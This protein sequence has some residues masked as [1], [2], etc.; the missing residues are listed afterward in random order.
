MQWPLA[1][2]KP[3]VQLVPS[4]AV[5][6]AGHVAEEPVHISAGSHSPV[7]GRQVCVDGANWQLLQ[8]SSLESSQTAL[9]LNLQVAA[10]QHWFPAQLAVPPQSQSSPA[11]T[12]PLPHCCPVIVVTPLLLL[13]QKVLTLFRWKAEQILP[14]EQGLNA[15]MPWPVEGFMRYFSPA[16]QVP[17]LRGQHC[18][19]LDV[20]SAQVELVQS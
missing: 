6:S 20:P 16:S 7:L 14:M 3:P 11:S 4:V 19:A 17:L 2:F 5:L 10:S 13:K 1:H 12:M 8:H 9:F 18:C 15:V